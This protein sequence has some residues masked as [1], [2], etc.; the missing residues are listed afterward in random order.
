MKNGYTMFG[1]SDYCIILNFN[2]LTVIKLPC[3]STHS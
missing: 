2:N 3:M 1:Q